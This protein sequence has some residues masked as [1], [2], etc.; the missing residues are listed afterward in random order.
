VAGGQRDRESVA[1]WCAV[2]IVYY[3]DGY[4]YQLAEVYQQQ[5]G[6]IPVSPGGN[7][8]VGLDGAGRL[9]I[10][11]GYAWDGASGPAINT[12]NFVRGSLVHDAL[13]QLIRLNVIALADRARADD[14]LREIVLADGMWPVRAWWV[15]QA[16][17]LFGSAYMR[18]RDDAPLSAP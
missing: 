7:R 5:T 18:G 8:F 16:V 12:R 11:A 15:H 14:L 10:A 13:Y 6:I 1:G 4:R 3:R 17:R 2:K 9:T